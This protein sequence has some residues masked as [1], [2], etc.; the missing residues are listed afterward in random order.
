MNVSPE[1]IATMKLRLAPQAKPTQKLEVTFNTISGQEVAYFTAEQTNGTDLA[2]VYRY[3][4]EARAEG[5]V[6]AN[7]NMPDYGKFSARLVP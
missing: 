4:L 6:G 5:V 7:Y 1:I 2:R 3:L